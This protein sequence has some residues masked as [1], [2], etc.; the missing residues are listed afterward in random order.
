MS[1]I[2]K[3][4]PAFRTV[5]AVLMALVFGAG[6][7]V[8]SGKNPYL[9]YAALFEGAF[10]DY[11]GIADTLVRMCPVIL[12]ALA[13][14]IPF[15]AGLFNIGAEGQIYA[16][17]LLSTLA[18]LY[19]EGFSVWLH[20]SI[21]FLAGFV[22]GALWALIPALLKAYYKV[23]ELIVS[24]MLNYVAINIV[25]FFL[26]GP[27]AVPDAPYPYSEAIDPK[28]ELAAIMPDTEVHWG[29]LLAISAAA[30]VYVLM[31]YSVLG[32]TYR[33]IGRS[34]E[35][36]LYAGINVKRQITTAFMLAGG[37]AGLAGVIE[38]LGVKFRLFHAFAAGVGFEGIVVAFLAQGHALL[39]VVAGYFFAGLQSGAG[40]MQRVVG[41][42]AY[43]IEALQGVIILFVTI[44]LSLRF[45]GSFLARILQNR[46]RR[47]ATAKNEGSA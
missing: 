38:V 26:Q 41:V 20:I 17:A 19:L 3:A 27:L 1:G 13:F 44:S 12:A 34:S 24:L 32:F 31:Q 21:C 47:P 9:A 4:L 15:R 25:G 6:L 10:F 36:A 42:D 35:A 16:G 46:G 5:I 23:N 30:L 11:W 39:V 43:V 18:A 14:L 29:V 33:T 37:L 7:I 8:A 45:R 28:L 22:G 40:T 2:A